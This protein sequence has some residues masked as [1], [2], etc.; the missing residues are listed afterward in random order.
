MGNR[1]QTTLDNWAYRVNK[2]KI[3]IPDNTGKISVKIDERTTIL[4]KPGT[5]INKILERYG[6]KI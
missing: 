2:K 5:D 6:K 4:V 1:K 3:Q